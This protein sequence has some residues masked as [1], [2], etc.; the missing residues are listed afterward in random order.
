LPRTESFVELSRAKFKHKRRIIVMIS[1]PSPRR[2]RVLVLS[3]SHLHYPVDFIVNA[4]VLS[5]VF[6]AGFDINRQGAD[7]VLRLT[8]YLDDNI[9]GAR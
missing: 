7:V 3:K 4:P 1:A 8:R 9:Q 6:G 2:I 5:D